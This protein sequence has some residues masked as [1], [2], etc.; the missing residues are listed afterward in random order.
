MT[1]SSLNLSHN[2]FA[3]RHWVTAKGRDL[4]KGNGRV[5]HEYHILEQGP[6]Q[7]IHY[8]SYQ[9]K[10]VDPEQKT[11]LYDVGGEYH[12]EIYVFRNSKMIGGKPFERFNIKD[13]NINILE[14]KSRGHQEDARAKGFIEFIEALKG[15]RSREEMTSDF[16][17]HKPAVMITS[18]IYQSAAA[19]LGGGNPKVSIP[20]FMDGTNSIRQDKADEYGISSTSRKSERTT[21][22]SNQ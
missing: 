15:I 11:G 19:Q 16:L 4:Y 17:S 6:F 9:S 18:A 12:L 20:F 21:C 7:S 22:S 14:G 5:R 3:K 13:L 8:H 1:V 10:E 2:G